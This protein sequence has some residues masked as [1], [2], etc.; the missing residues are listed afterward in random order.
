MKKLVSIVLAT[1]MTF[2][3]TVSVFAESLVGDGT[4]NSP[5]II[6]NADELSTL[7]T[8][9]NNSGNT[10]VYAKLSADITHNSNILLSGSLQLDL[11]QHTL[12]TVSMHLAAGTVHLLNGKLNGRIYAEEGTSFYGRNMHIVYDGSYTIY[13]IGSNDNQEVSPIIM[14]FTNCK[15]EH[16]S[17]YMVADLYGVEYRFTDCSFISNDNGH[18]VYLIPQ[19]C[20]I[21]LQGEKLS[22]QN[23]G[24]FASPYSI[25][26][27]YDEYWMYEKSTTTINY[28]VNPTYTVTIPA[29]IDAN[30]TA[31]IK[32]ENVVV[33]K[34]SLVA[35]TLTATNESDNSFK[36]RTTEGA[37]IEYQ[38]KNDDKI[39]S[40]NDTIL[41][42]NPDTDTNGST[43][44]SFVLPASTQFAGKYTGTVTFSIMITK[45]V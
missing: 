29:T 24:Q 39:V 3:M 42:V 17:Y 18:M 2:S 21:Y 14:D 15:I 44:L 26:A 30:T 40:L 35:V 7:V 27:G 16:S 9:V 1:F 43:N 34:G 22:D 11:D 28:S 5:Y 10:T 13:G 12:T 36:L 45:V 38:I 23:S 19:K 6:S 25:G 8:A 31:E 32:V 33:E 37:V 41:T 4:E 20:S